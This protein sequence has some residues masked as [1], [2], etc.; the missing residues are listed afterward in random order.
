M[1][2]HSSILAEKIPCPWGPKRVGHDLVTKQQRQPILI[3]LEKRGGKKK[4]TTTQQSLYYSRNKNA[5]N[6]HCPFQSLNICIQ[7]CKSYI[8]KTQT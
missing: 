1:A 2:S 6:F 7:D 5:A 3:P 8:R 4:Q